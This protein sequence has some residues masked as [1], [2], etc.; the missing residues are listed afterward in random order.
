[1][2]IGLLG[3]L[4]VLDD[5]DAPVYIA[6]A[7][8]RTLLIVLALDPGRLVPAGQ[9]VDGIWGDDPPA[10]AANALQALVS[11]LR[12]ALPGLAVES[13][14]AGYRL[15]LPPD[16]VDTA[17]F[18]RLVAA[19]RSASDDQTTA[20]RLG[21]ALALWRGPALLD[22]A[23]SEFFQAPRT[24]LEELRLAA[25]EERVDAALRLGRGAALTTELTTLVA[26]HPLRERL[27]GQLMRAL[28]AAGRPAEALAAYERT[29][30]ALADEL[31]T[32]PSAE[33]SAL[34]TGVLRGELAAPSSEPAP[35]PA[36][37]DERRATARTNLRTGLT[38]F[39]GRDAD[40]VRVRDLVG[41]YRLT[42]L[43]GPGGSGKTRLAGE[44]SRT[45]VD[46]MPDGVWLVELA[47][48]A[49]GADLPAAVLGAL[50]LRDQP[51]GGSSDDD[52]T[53]RL[54]AALRTRAAL[55][56]LD[57]CEH[58]IDAAAA[59]ADRLLGDCPD[60]RVL[61]T[62]REPLGITGEAVWPVE[63]LALP[64]EDDGAAAD[65]LGV[66]AVRLLVD[67]ARAVRPGFTLTEADA[68]AV[69]RICRALDGMP[70][71]IELAAARLRTMTVE[72]LAARLDDR[73]RLL[74]GGSRT[75]LPR[76]RTLR[77]VVDWS[78]GLLPE[79]E[80][81]VLRRL[82][83][84]AHGATADAAAQVCG[85]GADVLDQLISL[86]DKSL[87]VVDDDGDAP[88]YRMLETIKAY[89]LERLDEAG[90]LDAV[91]RAHLR[92]V[93]ELAEAAEPQLR[94]AEQL[95]WLRRL[96]AVHDDLTVALRGAAAAGDA[97]GALRLTV[98]ALWY[99]WLSGHRTE[100]AELTTAA[101]AVPGPADDV[102]RATAYAGLAMTATAGLGDEWIVKDWIAEAER[103]SGGDRSNPLLVMVGG[104]ADFMSPTEGRFGANMRSLLEND[105]PWVRALARL[106]YARQLSF[107]E[108]R[109]HVELALAEFRETG[110]RWGTSF[111]LTTMGDLEARQGDLA[112][113][114]RL[115]EE[116]IT[117]AT[118]VGTVEDVVFMRG[119]EAQLRWLL[120]DHEGS[121]AALARAE[122]DAAGLA[123][124]DSVA[125]LALYQSDLARWTGDL[126][127]ARVQMDR[128]ERLL[129]DIS[130]HPFF[131]AM[132]A[133][134][135]GH[136]AAAAG[137][138]ETAATERA[139]ALELGQNSDEDVLG[140][141]LVGAAD[142]ALRVGRP[143]DAVRLLAAVET[144]AGGLDRSA[145]EA[146]NA[147]EAARIA[148]G[149]GAASQVWAETVR[150][151]TGRDGAA[152][153]SWAVELAGS[154]LAPRRAGQTGDERGPEA[155]S[156]SSVPDAE[157][158]R[159]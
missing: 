80:R 57:N 131:L 123:W 70:L 159:P 78:W 69:A 101:L 122:H 68:P 46:R 129:Q 49:A 64:P 146:R 111:A 58:V 105:D 106:N 137:D 99:W 140:R 40:V 143:A 130:V 154:V 37:P 4:E 33:L 73:F 113:A 41:E 3:P 90:E 11:R 14:P 21:E 26:E 89:G 48:V 50:E 55:L 134:S 25:T 141:V 121:A 61:A 148:L 115:F 56:V 38:S 24:R 66:D 94:R 8:L 60:L 116:A 118:A 31:G 119:R 74:T 110:E 35:A 45:L 7:R 10:G 139:A 12:R 42:T 98:A 2:R 51:F 67:R 88:R 79:P 86:S 9:L 142:Q 77:A 52:A 157:P 83:V 30:E 65:L 108:R 29:R 18:E 151:L 114:L 149:D 63:P 15:A 96:R 44:A 92:Y 17:R 54:V 84:V 43:T 155:S 91:R 20:D 158:G 128:C 72:Q 102:T 87:L 47:P 28:V 59:L 13:H 147:D 144:L 85:D 62:S 82:A 133:T 34:H 5:D 109:E 75:A 120:G 107:A 136:L 81:V 127:T 16:A 126:D 132:V 22:V 103:L 19:A 97:R 6:G 95:V 117:C 152:A 125:G 36:P 112:A 100:G 93:T 1:M 23:E 124:A 71:A 104:L 145:P 27:V 32:D 150:D 156:T 138:L 76:H 53:G 153:H 39:I 135:R